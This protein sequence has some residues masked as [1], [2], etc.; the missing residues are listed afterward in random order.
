M[1][2]T[3]QSMPCSALTCY[4]CFHMFVLEKRCLLKCSRNRQPFHVL[5]APMHASN[6]LTF[7]KEYWLIHVYNLNLFLN[8][9]YSMP[10]KKYLGRIDIVNTDTETK[11]VLLID[12]YYTEGKR[13]SFKIH[14]IKFNF[15][16]RFIYW[17][18]I[19]GQD[20]VWSTCK[21]NNGVCEF[22]N[23]VEVGMLMFSISFKVVNNF[24]SFSDSGKNAKNIPV[25]IPIIMGINIR[26][27]FIIYWQNMFQ[28]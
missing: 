23:A 15:W 24:E 26:Y 13:K 16:W 28:V 25:K 6:I 11:L 14:C 4:F 19:L 8:S 2:T 20:C 5:H 18:L 7:N 3:K 21:I 1:T 17:A 22:S 9:R 10:T 12:S 27:G